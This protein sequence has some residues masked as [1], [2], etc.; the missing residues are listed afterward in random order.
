RIE[1]P[2]RREVD[3]AP[4]VGLLE[5]RP[6]GHHLRRLREPGLEIGADG[7]SAACRGV[8]VLRPLTSDLP[9]LVRDDGL[10]ASGPLAV[11]SDSR[12]EPHAVLVELGGYARSDERLADELLPAVTE[13]ESARVDS[14]VVRPLL[15]ER[16]L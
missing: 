8:V 6:R 15:R 4:A 12:P 14:P 1:E 16:V 5:G 3:E 2:Q 11:R 7:W 13:R 9:P 10:E